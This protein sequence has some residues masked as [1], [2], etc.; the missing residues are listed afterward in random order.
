DIPMPPAVEAALDR[1]EDTRQRWWI[2]SLLCNVL[3]VIIASLGTLVLFI[4]ADSW[5][6]L[7]QPFLWVMLIAW[8]TLT[9]TLFFN[10][11]YRILRYQ[12]TTEAAARRVEL[13]FPELG[14]HLINLIQLMNSS[15]G[16]PE[17][18]RQAAIAEAAGH[19]KGV[20]FQAAA[21]RQSR[22]DRWR[23]GLQTPRD[24]VEFGTALSLI[25]AA[26]VA[27]SIAVPTWRSS[28]DR[29]FTPW[30]FV[31]QTG[32]IQILE[33]TPGDSELLVG[34]R[35]EIG[36]KIAD[37]GTRQ[38]VATLFF[39]AEGDAAE[40]TRT[41]LPS[42]THDAFSFNLPS[43]NKPLEYR[44]QI[45]DSQSD[46]YRIGVREMPTVQ[47]VEI[48]Y[49]Y[50]SYLGLPSLTL[51]QK[52]ADLDAPQYT[53]A[54]IK[55]TCST[56][57][58]RGHA[59]FPSRQVVGRVADD[60]HVLSLDVP[61]SEATTFT[62]HLFNELGHTDAEPR[63]NNLH[64]SLDALPTV[65]IA[66]P[67][68]E[69]TT[70]PGSELTIV[71][72]AADDHGLG[73][74]RLEWKMADEAESSE[75]SGKTELLHQWDSV[76][77]ST[78]TLTH[79]LLLS[80]EQFKP[81]Q[82]IQVRAVA[83]D[84]RSLAV[85]GKQLE[86]Q[87]ATSSW[88][89]IKLISPEEEAS[90][91][92]ARIEGLSAKLW[93][94]LQTQLRARVTA[95]QVAKQESF[96]DAR[97]FATDVKQRQIQVQT[98]SADLAKSI[99][100]SAGENE[101]T[102][103]QALAKL[104]HGEMLQA[105]QQAERLAAV[106]LEG[107]VAELV[108]P[109]MESQDRVIEMLRKLLELNRRATSD[110]LAEMKERQGGD[111]PNDVQEKLM[112][113]SDKLQEFVKQ[114][115]KIIEATE[116][117]A[118]KP[119][120]DFT[121]EEEQLMKELAASE[122]EWSRFMQEVHSDFSKLPEQ[123][124]ANSSMLEELIEVQTE[125]KMAEGA[126]TK[127]AADI[128]VPLEQLGA[129]MAEELVTNIEKWLPDTPDRERWS[130]EEPLTDEMKEAPMAELPGELEDLVGELM[131]EEEDLFDEMEDMSSSWADSLDKGAGWDAAD[132][133]ISNMSAK[134]VTGNR[135]PNTSEISGRSG[136]GRQG[137]A[138]GEFVG[139]TAVGKGGRKTPSRLSPDANVKGQ[140]KDLSKDPVGGATGG[141]KESGAGGEGLE[142]PVP[143]QAKR[144]LERMANKQADL[145]NRAESV[146][147]KFQ[148]MNYHHTDLK[149]MTEMMKAVE[150][151]LRS[152]RYQSALRRREV[153]LDGLGNIK[154]YLDGE[155][156]VRRDQTNN[157]PEDIQKELLGSMLDASPAGWEE[158]NRKYF[159]R[160]SGSET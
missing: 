99:D 31:P 37:P 81:G 1:L 29:L 40:S 122:D 117:L 121:E 139:D 64:V 45:G 111:L 21:D 150:D 159:E 3:L 62:L 129:E 9:V 33:V 74:V 141:G 85:G 125:L 42:E 130:Q 51:H 96:D 73:A 68:R 94:I 50:P 115:K 148:V 36:A 113:L 61:M 133:P 140:I 112:A 152:G 23:N 132:G 35:L 126:L 70:A 135:L 57:V 91:T 105:A 15:N 78:A 104:A 145:R 93:A 123:D 154:T 100:A 65:Q 53:T 63:V 79:N 110:A 18:F 158:L 89:R 156:E 16:A 86:P 11:V 101:A 160:L 151:D 2:Y 20:R 54:H 147:V 107:D 146:D 120:E 144:E 102:V 32:S 136:E 7:S 52:H 124:F 118:K 17:E 46:V 75:E 41:M 39:K 90:D 4:M 155:F 142:G 28:A 149:R 22:W 69:T 34:S 55:L 49:E 59:Q 82:T 66:K 43:V 76:A 109:L 157:L 44:L 30:Q 5:L 103:K 14:S 143:P 108:S 98:N 67:S 114:Q 137:K 77:G 6:R 48:T 26:A 92:L 97:Q 128:A 8:T 87:E 56:A 153:M 27:F 38:P 71:V 84:R 12:R 13:S 60:S 127:K 116:N 131:E 138:S 119:V 19:V 134:G 80:T 72:R 95:A 106:K 47:D 58:A 83:L 10:T 88:I 25:I 24:L